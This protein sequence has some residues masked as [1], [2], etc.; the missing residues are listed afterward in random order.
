MEWN[1]TMHR[2]RGLTRVITQYFT[3]LTA[4]SFFPFDSGF[5]SAWAAAP[6]VS[7]W[8]FCFSAGTCRLVTDQWICWQEISLADKGNW[9]LDGSSPFLQSMMFISSWNFMQNIRTC[10]DDMTRRMTSKGKT[11]NLLSFSNWRWFYPIQYRKKTERCKKLTSLWDFR[12]K[13]LPPAGIIDGSEG[14]WNSKWATDRSMGLVSVSKSKKPP[15]LLKP[16]TT[17]R[18]LEITS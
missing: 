14:R 13:V 1:H 7:S 6:P 12:G 8:K 11:R 16:K 4:H 5:W 9:N 17:V 10:Q 18:K 15:L 3:E 2:C